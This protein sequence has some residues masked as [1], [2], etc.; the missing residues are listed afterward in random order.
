MSEQQ[1]SK[2]GG[3]QSDWAAR[4]MSFAY[5]P[6]RAN[7]IVQA[8]AHARALADDLTPSQRSMRDNALAKVAAL[9]ATGLYSMAPRER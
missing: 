2:Q 8:V 1:T 4:T 5:N 3:Q 7:P 9:R 6:M